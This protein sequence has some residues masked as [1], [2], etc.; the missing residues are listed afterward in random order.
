MNEDD[1]LGALCAGAGR[2]LAEAERP[3][4]ER[5]G[6]SMWQYVVLTALAAGSAPSQLVLAQQIRYDKTRLIAL[7]DAL[8]A[9][10]LVVRE[11]DPA[12]R[13]ARVVHLTREG[14]TR[15]AAVRSA[16]REVEDRKLA[17]LPPEVR[18]VLRSALAHL[19]NSV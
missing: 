2:N 5:H 7:L 11:P 14:A 8:E 18:Q 10:G 16:I 9:E 15:H 19:A 6:L 13:R 1:D 4:L 12:D 3:V 17:G